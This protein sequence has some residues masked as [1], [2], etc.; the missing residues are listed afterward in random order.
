M[1]VV[2]SLT[3]FEKTWDELSDPETLDFT[4][5][6]KYEYGPGLSYLIDPVYPK[7]WCEGEGAADEVW[8]DKPDSTGPYVC[9][10]NIDGDR[11][12]FELRDDYYMDTTGYPTSITIK[13]Y[14]EQTALFTDYVTGTLDAAFGLATNDVESLMAG[15]IPNTAYKIAAKNDVFSMCLC[16]YTEYFQDE[17][18]RLAIAHCIDTEAVAYAALG[19]LGSPAT[20]TLPAGVNYYENVGAYEYDVELAKEYLAKS[21]WPDG[22]TLDT[23]VVTNDAPTVAIATAVQGYLAQI[24]I[25][26][27]F[28]AYSVMVAVGEYFVT[29]VTQTS[30]KNCMEGSPTL[31]PDQIYDTIGYKS[32]NIASTVSTDP[33]DDFNTHLYKALGEIDPAARA[34]DYSFVQNYLK[35]TAIQIPIAEAYLGYCYRTDYVT[36]LNAVSPT[37][38]Q[39]RF[40]TYVGEAAYNGE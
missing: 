4:L 1:T 10:E 30:F 19:V 38:P 26:M 9:V 17:N 25:D 24:G 28:E 5:Y 18:V 21:P 8:W 6:Y 22:F 40:A 2:Y 37:I 7:D 23:V 32:T 36:S 20:S 11:A 12:T 15:E 27:Q 34:E 29:G 35:D 13:F 33:D 16:P 39:L 14:T 31:D 3:P